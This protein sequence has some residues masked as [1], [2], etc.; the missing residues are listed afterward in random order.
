MLKNSS[1][2]VLSEA[3]NVV[4]KSFSIKSKQ[5]LRRFVIFFCFFVAPHVW[6]ENSFNSLFSNSFTRRKIP[7]DFHKLVRWFSLCQLMRQFNLNRFLIFHFRDFLCK[8]ETC[9]RRTS[10]LETSSCCRKFKENKR[11]RLREKH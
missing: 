7:Q 11:L 6:D 9:L 5:F 2:R 4:S 10:F 3:V 8:R 1:R